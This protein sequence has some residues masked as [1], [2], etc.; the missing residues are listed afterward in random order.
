MDLREWT[1]RSR[2]NTDENTT[3][4]GLRA[5][6][7]LHPGGQREGGGIGV[8]G[9]EELWLPGLSSFLLR[10]RPTLSRLRGDSSPGVRTSASLLQCRLV[11]SSQEVS[12]ILS[13]YSALCPCSNSL[14]FFFVRILLIAPATTPD[15][16]YC[17]TQPLGTPCAT[18]RS[19]WMGC[20]RGATCGPGSIPAQRAL[21]SHHRLP[22]LASQ[23]LAA[24]APR[25]HVPHLLPFE[26]GF[27]GSVY[28]TH[29][30]EKLHVPLAL[31][32]H[33]LAFQNAL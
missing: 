17:D 4:C 20:H 21:S 6:L 32:H 30:L 10:F 27:W 31:P 14:C 1:G 26:V 33:G 12:K 22:R 11:L 23:A 7:L 16:L 19:S 3:S 13:C 2:Q 24:A 29:Q 5:A 25:C 9:G 8:G 28:L 15:C 18:W